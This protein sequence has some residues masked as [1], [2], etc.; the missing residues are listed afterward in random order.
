[1]IKDGSRSF[2][3]ERKVTTAKV[4]LF[5]F[6]EPPSCLRAFSVLR[7][8]FSWD[9]SS[10]ESLSLLISSWRPSKK[11]PLRRKSKLT[12]ILRLA[13]S[14]KSLRQ[15]GTP[16]LQIL[17]W[18]LL[19]RLPQKSYWRSLRLFR[20]SVSQLDLSVHPQLLDLL[21]STCWSSVPLRLLPWTSQNM[22][23]TWESS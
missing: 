10:L 12:K 7:T 15:F 17:P 5:L 4:L 2:G 6:L 23:W 19:D 13:K 16:P 20:T 8:P 11:S 9:G 3:T 18:W 1:M 21:L 14:T 22:S